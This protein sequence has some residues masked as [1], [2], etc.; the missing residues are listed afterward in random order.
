MLIIIV[1][2]FTPQS[3]PQF[4]HLISVLIFIF[5]RDTLRGPE[6]L[7]RNTFWLFRAEERSVCSI[8]GIYTV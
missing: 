6:I 5:G 3:R 4:V 8:C 7:D 2:S 1:M